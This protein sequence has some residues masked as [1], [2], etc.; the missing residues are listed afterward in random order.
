M[1]KDISNAQVLGAIHALDKK[2]N[3]LEVRVN[4]NTT[5]INDVFT[6]VQFMQGEMVT[7]T[8]LHERFTESESRIMNHIDGTV[9]LYTK[10][11]IEYASLRSKTDRHDQQIKHLAKHT[12]CKLPNP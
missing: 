12:H 8:E 3:M 11:D 9:Q 4:E 6:I 7:K 2:F 1:A 10:L 5:R